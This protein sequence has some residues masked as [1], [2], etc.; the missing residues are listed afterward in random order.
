MTAKTATINY[1][2]LLLLVRSESI[3]RLLQGLQPELRAERI[4]RVDGERFR[5]ARVR[6]IGGLAG[7]GLGLCD[8][9]LLLEQARA[10]RLAVRV[11]APWRRRRPRVGSAPT[12][13]TRWRAPPSLAGARSRVV[14]I[15]TPTTVTVRCAWARAR[16]RR[17]RAPPGVAPVVR[18]AARAPPGVAPVVRARAL[19]GIA[20]PKL[21]GVATIARGPA[22]VRPPA[23]PRVVAAWMIR[24]FTLLAGR[25]TAIVSVVAFRAID[26]RHGSRPG[27]LIVLDSAGLVVVQEQIVVRPVARFQRPCDSRCQ[28]FGRRGSAIS[29]L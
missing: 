13:M 6:G 23:W 26:L 10:L 29:Q 8:C 17:A 2:S 4:R 15:V 18:A 22:L 12:A 5:P 28:R 9:R 19:P 7:L 14:G 21:S 20:A 24:L 25:A 16:A 3:P 27:G 1:D 11:A